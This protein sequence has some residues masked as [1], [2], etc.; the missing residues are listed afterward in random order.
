MKQ[1]TYDRVLDMIRSMS[2]RDRAAIFE[3]QAIDFRY[4]DIGQMVL[5]HQV[6]SDYFP[7]TD[8]EFWETINSVKARAAI[9]NTAYDETAARRVVAA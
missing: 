2:W 3:E 8:S 1:S 7:E 5:A 6:G 9:G 4:N